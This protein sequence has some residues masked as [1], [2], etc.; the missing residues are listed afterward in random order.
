MQIELLK[1]KFCVCKIDDVSQANIKSDFFF[2]ANTDSEV[3][4]VCKEVDAPKDS[5]AVDRSWRAL[6]IVGTLDF[7]LVGIL[8]KISTVLANAG[9]PIFAVSTYDTDYILIKEERVDKACR[10]LKKSGYSII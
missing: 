1:D 9:V 3:S 4:L 2:L 10:T 7:S 5:V 6:R 8:S